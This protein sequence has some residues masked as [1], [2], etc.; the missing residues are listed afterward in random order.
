MA[1][2]KLQRYPGKTCLTMAAITLPLTMSLLGCQVEKE[3]E[4]DLPDVDVDVEG[5]RMPDYDV[6]VE[7]PE[8]DVGTTTKTVKVPKVKVVVEEEEIEVPYIDVDLA[9]DEDDTVTGSTAFADDDRVGDRTAFADEER[10]ELPAEQPGFSG[11]LP[12][13]PAADPVADRFD[14]A[15]ERSAGGGPSTT[16]PATDPTT[17]PMRLGTQR[18]DA[19]SDVAAGPDA[20]GTGADGRRDQTLTVSLDVPEERYDVA[21]EEIY[22][23]DRA[24]LVISRLEEDDPGSSAGVVS[25]SGRN[26][27][28]TVVVRA[29]EIEVRHYIIGER[30][31]GDPSHR[32][33]E[34]RGEIA[35]ELRS[36]RL[37]YRADV[38]DPSRPSRN[39][40]QS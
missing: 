24:L 2:S 15:E 22:L 9:G 6:D 14:V 5:G 29:P 23:V 39:L 18:A 38:P 17:D 31:E 21:I 8:V 27:S 12:A 28:D 4:G 7:V 36:A 35:G 34:D 10:D 11:D 40:S 20:G 37:I 19:T 25:P 1:R 13:N 30:V 33:I 16:D 32:F 3:Q 26:A